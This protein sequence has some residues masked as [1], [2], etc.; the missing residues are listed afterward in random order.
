MVAF[1]FVGGFWLFRWARLGIF[2]VEEVGVGRYFVCIFGFV[3]RRF[4][5]VYGDIGEFE[6]FEVLGWFRF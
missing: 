5:V 3:F 6:F 4:Y 2:G 1:A